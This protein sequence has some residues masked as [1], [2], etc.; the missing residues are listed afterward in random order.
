MPAFAPK[1]IR[2]MNEVAVKHAEEWLQ[3]RL[4]VFLENEES[5]D[6]VDEMLKLILKAFCETAM[7][8]ELSDEEMNMFLEEW[9]LMARE[10]ILKS[11]SNPLR[12]YLTPFLPERKRA[13]EASVKV[14]A[15]FQKIIDNYRSLDSPLEGTVINLIM[16]N[17]TFKN[18]ASIISEIFM[19]FVAGHDTT[20][21]SLSWILKALGQNLSVQNELRQALSGLDPRDWS[22]CDL[23]RK[24]VQEGMRIN[25]VGATG[26]TRVT[27]RDFTTSKGHFIPKGSIVF[28]PLYL[29]SHNPDIFESPERFDP[30]RW[31][32]PT[33]QMKKAHIPFALGAQNCAGQALANA[34]LHSVLVTLLQEYEFAVDEE[35][36]GE[37][38]LV[39]KPVG[40]KMKARKIM[41]A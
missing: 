39:L 37:F 20:A 14:V 19:Y 13:Q 9:D 8:Y 41:S 34:E 35:G 15:L 2:R 16:K 25:P 1:H 7:E 18:D 4:P 24:T 21:V 30:S 3:N 11:M 28:L 40:L 33:D 10:Y 5:F 27:G 23:L 32:N 6:I 31:D 17:P 22:K 29:L 36:T 26:N 38:H 12:Q